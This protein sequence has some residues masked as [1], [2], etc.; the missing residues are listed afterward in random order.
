MNGNFRAEINFQ[1][2]EIGEEAGE[3]MTH[4]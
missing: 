3:V 4:L 1:T 2:V